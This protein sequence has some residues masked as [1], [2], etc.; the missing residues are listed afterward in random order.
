M[1]AQHKAMLDALRSGEFDH[2]LE[3][4]AEPA[5]AQATPP[6]VDGG[7]RGAV[8][9]SGVQQE[10]PAVAPE[11]SGQ[12]AAFA[13][14]GAVVANVDETAQSDAAMPPLEL[15]LGPAPVLPVP[16]TA[17]APPEDGAA[18][19]ADRPP[20]APDLPPVPDL[21]APPT[22]PTPPTPPAAIA[23]PAAPPRP[24]VPRPRRKRAP[25]TE[26]EVLPPAD[27]PV[28][29]DELERAAAEADEDFYRELVPDAAEKATGGRERRPTPIRA[30]TYSYI[31]DDARRPD[32][33]DR[34]A[35]VAPAAPPRKKRFPQTSPGRRRTGAAAAGGASA[36]S[37]E[38]GSAEAAGRKPFGARFVSERPLDEVILE[39]LARQHER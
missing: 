31:A 29:V 11:A 25:T 2:M 39:F 3:P 1:S 16:S 7:P 12:L 17:Q 30:G 10:V 5:P 23:A 34:P 36:S 14:E 32:G 27:E 38:A 9:P 37:A 28:S 35:E 22:P 13:P 15:E 18:A 24:P 4:A 6:A 33:R 20:P 21:P 8:A 19:A 26:P